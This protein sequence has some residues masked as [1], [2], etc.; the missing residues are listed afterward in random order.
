MVGELLPSLERTLTGPFQ[1]TSAGV[2]LGSQTKYGALE[3]IG[4]AST[5]CIRHTLT[6]C[7]LVTLTHAGVTLGSQTKYEA[8]ELLGVHALPVS[9]SHSLCVGWLH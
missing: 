3:L 1:V 4:C 2:T 5:P 9:A 6:V 8:L 7:G